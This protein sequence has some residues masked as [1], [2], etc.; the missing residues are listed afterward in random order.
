MIDVSADT[1][2]R[3]RPAPERTVGDQVVVARAD[4][5]AALVLPPT[6]GV[7]WAALATWCRPSDLA[8]TLAER[9]PD[10][11]SAERDDALAGILDLLDEAGLV[12]RAP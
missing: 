10:V 7:V 11:P 8:A 9:Y 1:R 12:E 4:T 2:I 3:R 6:A 5:D